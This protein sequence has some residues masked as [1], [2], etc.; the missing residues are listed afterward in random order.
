MD[1]IKMI[2]ELRSQKER[3]AR[4][5]ASMEKLQAGGDGPVRKRRGRKFMSPEERRE[6]S[7]RMKKY[8][9]DRHRLRRP[10]SVRKNEVKL[11]PLFFRGCPFEDQEKHPTIQW[12]CD[13]RHFGIK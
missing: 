7:A 5:I 9:A 2:D 10:S 8:W 11:N 13:L 3:L 1:L 12:G 4:A 6:V